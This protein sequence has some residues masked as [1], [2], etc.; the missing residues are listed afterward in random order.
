MKRINQKIVALT[1]VVTNFFVTAV[2][3][4]TGTTYFVSPYGGNFS[5]EGLITIPLKTALELAQAGDT[6][7][8]MSGEYFQDIKTTREG[9]AEQPIRI[10]GTSGVVLKGTG[11][12]SIVDIRHSYVELDGFTIDGLV[13]DGSLPQDYRKKLVYIKGIE[14][15]G[16]QGVKLLNM[17][18]INARDECVRLKYFAQNIEIAN[19]RISH[20]GVQDYLFSGGG[21]NGEA[22]YIGTAP[23]Q[24]YKNPTNETDQSDNNWIHNN[25]LQPFGSECVDVKEGSSFNIIEGNSCSQQKDPNVG[26][27]SI[28]GNQNIVRYNKIYRNIG[29]GVRLGGD[30]PS[31]GIYN[32]VYE[33]VF[34]SNQFSALKIMVEPQG[35]ICNNRIARSRQQRTIRTKSG[36]EKKQFLSACSDS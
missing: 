13:G 1:I 19:S 35:K 2:F 11:K 23:E 3:A 27:V 4:E 31:D 18:I 29:A 14:N 36:I 33:N 34:I 22:I 21:H 9:T 26:G 28:R 16:V 15:I 7:Q 25:I 17:E 24:L 8:L 5:G 12:T 10:I 20:C 30:T 32:D 6:I